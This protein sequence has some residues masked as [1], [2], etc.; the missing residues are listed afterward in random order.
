MIIIL[1]IN[2]VTDIISYLLYYFTLYSASGVTAM[3]L[4]YKNMNLE[5]EK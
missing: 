3:H 5:L 2:I 1:K 4:F